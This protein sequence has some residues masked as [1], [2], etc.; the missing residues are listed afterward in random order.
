MAISFYLLP[1]PI[2]TQRIVRDSAL[3]A[4]VAIFPARDVEQV[5]RS[6]QHLEA[7]R[8]AGRDAQYLGR[9]VVAEKEF[10]GRWINLVIKY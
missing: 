8:Y 4:T 7:V 9:L 5:C 6:L 3:I 1:E 2:I 10:L